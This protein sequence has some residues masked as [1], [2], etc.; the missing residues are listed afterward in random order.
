VC[1]GIVV[2]LGDLVVDEGLSVTSVLA[3]RFGIAALVLACVLAG[4]RRPLVAARGERLG[5]VIV[6][7][8]GYAAE[9]SVFF[10]ALG[11]G[12]AAAVT[13]LFY[14]YPVFV[15]IGSWALLSRGVPARRIL[16]ALVL[17]VGGAAIVVGL[18]GSL[19]IEPAGVAL[20]IASAIV[21]TGYMLGAD[22]VFRRTLPLT[23]AMWV[24]GSASL[25]LFAWSFGT[26]GWLPP[27]G[28]E[29]WAPIVAMG[30]ATA[31]AFVCLLSGIQRLGAER[32]SIVASL[33]PLAAALLAWAFRGQS[34]GLGVALGG[35]LI[36]GGAVLASVGAARPA[37]PTEIR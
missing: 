32:A 23:S 15:A 29:Q 21:I 4:L 6:A 36:L 31:A 25:A 1:F 10:A 20:S 24:S 7:V 27:S 13:L 35:A 30:L 8:V 34:L 11:H 33:E 12:S 37:V 16:A 18:G 9:A 2:V 22:V 26:R 19:A 5:A 3:V 28:W 17:A 14:L